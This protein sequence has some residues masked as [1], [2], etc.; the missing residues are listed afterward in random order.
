MKK[1]LICLMMLG[2]SVAVA[3]EYGEEPIAY[4][5]YEYTDT[6]YAPTVEYTSGTTS[7]RRDNYVG[8]R[9]QKNEHIEFDYEIEHGLNTNVHDDNFGLNLMVGNRLTDYVK[10]EFETAYT[11]AEFSKYDINFDYSIWSNMMNV[12][13]FREFDGAVAPYAGIGLGFATIWSDVSGVK[14]DTHFD[15]TWQVMLGVNFALNERIDLNVGVK[16]QNYGKVEHELKK[17]DNASTTIDATALY[18]GA[19]YKFGL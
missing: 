15:L 1:L 2:T 14:S 5:D 3:N 7:E 9:I 12:Y 8:F 13:M 10:I 6:Y 11:G 19:A 4:D 17:G 16:Y 18:F